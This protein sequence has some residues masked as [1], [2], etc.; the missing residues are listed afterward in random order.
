[1]LNLI[2]STAGMI[3]CYY[4]TWNQY[5]WDKVCL[6]HFIP[7]ESSAELN[8]HSQPSKQPVL[9]NHLGN[10]QKN[11]APQPGLET[12]LILEL[13]F[14]GSSESC[15]KGEKAP[16]FYLFWVGKTGEV[17]EEGGEGHCLVDELCK[18]VS[19]AGVCVWRWKVVFQEK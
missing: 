12:T 10:A 3:F 17:M 1:M 9:W 4:F 16:E 6:V 5:S 18:L 2:T 7:Y 11:V 19:Q 15:L 14:S 8:I 13:T